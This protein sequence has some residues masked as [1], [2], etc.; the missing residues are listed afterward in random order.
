MCQSST[1]SPWADGFVGDVVA[2]RLRWTP[3]C[4]T[5]QRVA[6]TIDRASCEHAQGICTGKITAYDPKAGVLLIL[7][8]ERLRIS[9]MQTTDI[10]VSVPVRRFHRLQRLLVSSIEVRFIDAPSFRDIPDA[11]TIGAGCV[12]LTS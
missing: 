10:L 8:G 6:L 3:A 4:I 5:G 11:E 9:E 12:K 7:L 2:R 1:Q